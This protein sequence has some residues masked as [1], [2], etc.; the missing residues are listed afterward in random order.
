[1]AEQQHTHH[2]HHHSHKSDSAHS[3]K[4]KSLAAIK[5]RKVIER[6]LKIALCIVAIIMAIAV[7][8]VYTIG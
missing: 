7:V 2:H 8:L 4:K 1:M 3:F 6:V 5:R